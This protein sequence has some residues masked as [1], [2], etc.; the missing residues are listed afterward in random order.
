MRGGT[1]KDILNGGSGHDLMFGGTEND[2]LNGGL[3][4]DR[5]YGENG[6]DTLDGGDGRDRLYGG[7]GNDILRGGRGDDL[8][9][10]GADKDTL[11]GGQGRD[12]FI[13]TSVE[14]FGD[15]ITDFEI[16]KDRINFQQIQGIQSMGNLRFTQR[17]DDT[18]L[19][20][21]INGNLKTVA[22]LEDVNANTLS[23]RHF[24][25]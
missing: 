23:Q 10:G 25:F 1:G 12:Q 9:V 6:R 5:L 18:L 19:R 24:I 2:I 3:G 17:G 21:N 13:Y 16:V 11:T 22:V 14:D 7:L 15:V 4:N 8:L 20:A